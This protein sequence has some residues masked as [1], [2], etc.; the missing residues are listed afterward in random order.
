[1]RLLR[2]ASIASA[3]ALLIALPSATPTAAG[4]RTA[5]ITVDPAVGPPTTVITVS[6]TGFGARERV[7]IRFDQTKVGVETTQ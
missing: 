2:L 4:P 3:A 7:T 5:A 6:G 1:M